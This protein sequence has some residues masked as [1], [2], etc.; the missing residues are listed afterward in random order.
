[1]PTGR[2][3][4]SPTGDLHVG[5]LR[6]ALAAWLFARSAD[7]RFLL[8]FEDLDRSTASTESE[9]GQIA[10][11]SRLGIDWDA[12]PI[13]QSDRFDLYHDAIADLTRAGLTYR[14]WCSRREVREAAA[15]PH[16]RLGVYPGTCRDIPARRIAELEQ[17]GRPA[18][19]RLRCSAIHV[20]VNDR[21]R[22]TFTAE[23]DDFVLRR[24][25]GVPAY[26]LAVV[27]D[28]SALGIEEVV[29]ADD[30]L[31]STPRHVHL[32]NLLEL[33]TPAYAHVPLVL[34]GDG[35]RLAKRDGAVTLGD[36]LALGDTPGRVVAV[37]AASLGID[38]PEHEVSPEQLIQWFEPARIKLKPWS[39]TSDQVTYPW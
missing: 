19:L 26:N 2:F 25:D 20:T 37:L 10:D 16:N 36:R 35:N 30:L 8:R 6:T 5:N 28:D 14:C 13:R 3:A 34:A 4:P 12:E 9:I 11:L 32:Q 22:E 29:R 7:S 39:L 17:S 15:A 21:L 33:A 23:V 18:A 27:I 31:D 38:V 1:M 24:G